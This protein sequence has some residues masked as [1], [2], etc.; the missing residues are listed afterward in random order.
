MTRRIERGTMKFFFF[1][2]RFERGSTLSLCCQLIITLCAVRWGIFL[3]PVF[4]TPTQSQEYYSL[5]CIFGIQIYKLGQ[6]IDDTAH[7][8]ITCTLSRNLQMARI[9]W[10]VR[11]HD[12]KEEGSLSRRRRMLRPTI[13]DDDDDDYEDDEDDEATSTTTKRRFSVVA[14]AGRRSGKRV[15]RL[16][17]WNSDWEKGGGRWGEII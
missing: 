6:S 12:E 11:M 5:L 15:N 14:G 4:I 8:N 16:C 3:Q 1:F 9:I 17:R 10:V 7:R 13:M 2:F